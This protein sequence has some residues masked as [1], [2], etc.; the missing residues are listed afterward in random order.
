[1]NSKILCILAVLII[2]TLLTCAK[3]IT[4]SQNEFVLADE[5]LAKNE[6][7]KATIHYERALHW[8]LPFFQTPYQAAEKLWTIAEILH[9]QNQIAEALK[10][11]RILRSAFYSIRSFYTPGKNWIHRCNERIAHLM[12]EKFIASQKIQ[13][14]S[15]AD[16]KSEY[17][18][19][20]EEDRPPYT[21]YSVINEV[22][23]FGWVFSIF[24]FIFKALT[25]QGKIK[26]HP[27]ILFISSFFLFYV[28]WVWGLLNA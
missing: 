27:A 15:F 11:Y 14:N 25:P 2:L 8:Y 19:L 20:L 18:F 28:I 12:A 10:T 23:F 1:M 24:L 16:K 5:H 6:L 7:S 22:G 17:L 21:F 4:N 26:K 9:S 13:R 3:I